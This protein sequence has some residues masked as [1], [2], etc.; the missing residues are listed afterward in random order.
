MQQAIYHSLQENKD[1]FLYKKMQGNSYLYYWPLQS[2]LG[3]LHSFLQALKYIQVL[4]G[5][6]RKMDQ[7]QRLRVIN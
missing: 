2:V 5:L 7:L 6:P 1:T 4:S 3:I